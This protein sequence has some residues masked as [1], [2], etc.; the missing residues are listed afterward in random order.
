MVKKNVKAAQP[1]KAKFFAMSAV[2]FCTFAHFAGLCFDF[3]PFTLDHSC[4]HVC[5]L[6]CRGANHCE[7]ASEKGEHLNFG[8]TKLR[9]KT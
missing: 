8:K 2:F 7:K 5:C 3:S 6:R 1:A 9:I 4:N